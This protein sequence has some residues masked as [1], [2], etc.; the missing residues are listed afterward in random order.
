MLVCGGL[1]VRCV[2]GKFVFCWVSI[3]LVCNGLKVGCL[4]G[5]F[6]FCWVSMVSRVDVCSVD[7]RLVG[8]R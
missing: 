6:A 1:E 3:M 2:F 7:L 8:F 5:R 4:F